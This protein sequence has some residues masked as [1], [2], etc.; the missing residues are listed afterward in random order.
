[1]VT[2]YKRWCRRLM[3]PDQDRPLNI[4]SLYPENAVLTLFCFAK[5]RCGAKPD[6]RYE[7]LTRDS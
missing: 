4:R 3:W 2:I 5:Q 7:L 1:M 6:Q